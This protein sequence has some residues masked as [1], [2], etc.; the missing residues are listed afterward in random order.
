MVL[1]PVLAKGNVGLDPV[2]AKALRGKIH[3]TFLFVG[4]KLDS[5][6]GMA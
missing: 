6:S 1:H 3:A 5:E 4:S 2:L